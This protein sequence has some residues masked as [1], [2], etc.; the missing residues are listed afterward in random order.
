MM[1]FSPMLQPTQIDCIISCWLSELVV[2]CCELVVSVNNLLL[3]CNLWTE[4]CPELLN[5][6]AIFGQNYV[7]NYL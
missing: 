4:L 3:V 5:D 6:V 1:T 7:F 2:A